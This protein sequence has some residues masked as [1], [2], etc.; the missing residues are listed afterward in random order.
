MFLCGCRDVCACVRV[1]VCVRV[2]VP[3]ARVYVCVAVITPFWHL[4]SSKEKVL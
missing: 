3:G 1:S 4:M 2:C